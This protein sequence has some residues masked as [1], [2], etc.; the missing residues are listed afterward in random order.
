MKYLTVMAMKLASKC[1]IKP[2]YMYRLS[3]RELE[4]VQNVALKIGNGKHCRICGRGPFTHRG[5]YLHFYKVHF[6]EI[7][8]MIQSE[9]QKA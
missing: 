1:C 8:R 6:D 4:V 7:R 2:K 3:A 9:L 5:L